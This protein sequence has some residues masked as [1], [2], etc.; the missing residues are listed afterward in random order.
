MFI[1][2]KY[3]YWLEALSLCKSISE[4][5]LAI[6]KLKA[7]VKVMLGLAILSIYNTR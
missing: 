2:E 3:L 5:I 6:A 1:R 4:G 7:L